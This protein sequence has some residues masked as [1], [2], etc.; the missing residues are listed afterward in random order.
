M[1]L[2]PSTPAR[3]GERGSATLILFILLGIMLTLV[4]VN[5][6]ALIRLHREIKWTEQKQEQRLNPPPPSVTPAT[7]P[8]HE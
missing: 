6:R 7:A 8:Q 2:K 4:L 3:T 1:K 5:S